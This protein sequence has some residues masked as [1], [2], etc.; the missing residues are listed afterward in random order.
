MITDQHNAIAHNTCD[1]SAVARRLEQDIG[2]DLSRVDL[3]RILRIVEGQSTHP[4]SLQ[5]CCN[6]VAAMIAVHETYFL[7]HQ[8]HYRWIEDTWFPWIAQRKQRGEKI[9]LLSAGCS[10]GEE[11]YSLYAHLIDRAQAAGLRLVVDAIDINAESIN[12]ARSGKY[13][14]WSMRGV[15]LD[16]ESSWLNVVARNIYVRDDIRSQV[17][18]S[19]HNLMKPLSGNKQYD[20]VLCRNVL[21]YMHKPAV[22]TIYQNLS[23]ALAKDGIIL[24]GPSDPGPSQAALECA[25][26][27]GVRLYVPNQHPLAREHCG[28]TDKASRHDGAPAQAKIKQALPTVVDATSHPLKAIDSMQTMDDVESLLRSGQYDC[29]RRVL[30]QH[31]QQNRFDV[32]AYVML[33]VLALDMDNCELARDM[34]RKAV[35]I[36]PESVYAAFVSADIKT[37]Y[38]DRKGAWRDLAWLEEKLAHMGQEDRIRYCEDITVHQL[39]QVVGIRLGS[40]RDAKSG[41]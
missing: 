35:F 14:L 10:T 2:L 13:G 20:L 6:S 23:V 9:H 29:A 16:K 24:P 34:I 12:I 41:H 7:R 33:A 17:N 5:E 37:R 27:D 21:I 15:D 1:I 22:D 11:P 39:R 8:N 4:M 40:L 30:E 38:G 18:F 3:E 26:Q 25:W 36:E 31:L 19:Q 32:R 28:A